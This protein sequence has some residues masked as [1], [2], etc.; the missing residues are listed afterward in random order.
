MLSLYSCYYFLFYSLATGIDIEGVKS[1]SSQEAKHSLGEYATLYRVYE[2]V[3]R[4]LKENYDP[5]LVQRKA[6]L[7]RELTAREEQ[8]RRVTIL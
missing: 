7:A 8:I 6:E 4:C 1:R 2:Q 5:E 3:D